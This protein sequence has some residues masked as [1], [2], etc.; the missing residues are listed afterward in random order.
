VR[1]LSILPSMA[2]W[3]ILLLLVPAIVVPVAMLVGFA[4]CAAIAGIEDWRP[5]PTNGGDGPPM[6]VIES[7]EGKSVS[8]I[9][10]KWKF[11]GSAAKFLIKRSGQI[12]STQPV[13]SPF[14]D[15]SG[16]EADTRIKCSR[17][18]A[19]TTNSATGPMK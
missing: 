19:V 10:L 3:L 16:L 7:A 13:S 11:A 9:T 5:Q 12:L 4:G 15:D 2:E 1:N 8:V 17:L 6:P 14:D 18:T